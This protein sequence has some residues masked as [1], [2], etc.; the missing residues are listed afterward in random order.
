M[1]QIE[2]NKTSKQEQFRNPAR[3]LRKTYVIAL[4]L[5]AVL[6]ISSQWVIRTALKKQES[7]SRVVNIA[8]QQR[9]LSQKVSRL[10]LE[11]KVARSAPDQ[12][13]G[14]VL[15]EL[16]KTIAVWE[17]QQVALRN[18]SEKL[19]IPDG[20]NSSA[21]NNLYDEIDDPFTRIV[22]ATRRVL[23]DYAKYPG[24]VDASLPVI[25]RNSDE[26]LSG[27]IEIVNTYDQEARA[28]VNRLENIEL[29]LMGITLTTLLLEAFLV[30][31]P[32]VKNMESL[33][34]SI[35]NN[36]RK[37]QKQRREL[38]TANS[39]L[40][41]QRNELEAANT[42]LQEKQNELEQANRELNKQQERLINSNT[43]LEEARHEA[44]NAYQELQ[45]TQS[46]I[47]QS[48]KMA[49]LGQLIA[50]IAHEINTPIGAIRASVDNI[51]DTQSKA[52]AY[53]TQLFKKLSD[54]DLKRLLDLVALSLNSNA[55][56]SS[57]EER[58]LR[59]KLTKSLEAAG[60]DDGSQ[61]ADKLVDMGITEMNDDLM[62]LL[63]HPDNEL[64]MDTA[65]N[66]AMQQKDTQNIVLAV[67]RVSKIV[68]SLKNYSRH[69]YTGEMTSAKTTDGIETV[70][71][72]YHNQLKHDVEVSKEYGEIPDT[73]CY[74]DELNQIWT[75]L[76]HNSLQAMDH[77]GSIDISVY[78]QD[79]YI[80]HHFTDSGKGIPEEIKAR[81]FDPFFTTKPAGEGSGLGLDIVKKIIKKHEGTID[82]ASQPGRTTFSIGIPVRHEPPQ[83]DQ[84]APVESASMAS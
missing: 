35:L 14:P 76:I 22:Q 13:S 47:V 60:L 18:G 81:I 68:F 53:S 31:R 2:N 30:F 15:E 12:S 32:A 24:I 37:L 70:L 41:E 75:N 69:N 64:I 20:F 45:D 80:M 1:P 65:Y 8:G 48:E 39:Q 43:Q 58:K 6:T 21:V 25:K 49:A 29:G 33:F 19:D 46:Q 62:P 36:T 3:K 9:A 10:V 57:R 73:Y 71:T 23:A 26:Y 56:L 34:E 63:A 17:N 5:V 28:K 38:R 40:S 7:D 74:P 67:D 44:Q 42:T 27:M 59:R 50:G 16:E 82:V 77:T 55:N 84:N 51:T 83:Q 61:V 66:L 78:E 4:S 52:L 72:L 54:E 11:L 79:G